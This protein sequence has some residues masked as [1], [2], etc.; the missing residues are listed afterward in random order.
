MSGLFASHLAGH[1]VVWI[2]LV[3]MLCGLIALAVARP[4]PKR[5]S[6]SVGSRRLARSAGCVLGGIVALYLV[7]R[8]IAEFFTVGY[9]NPASYRDSWGG[10]SL[11]GVL[12]V[13]SGPGTAI[14]IATTGYV[15]GW[16]PRSRRMARTDPSP[17]R[18]P[19][20]QTR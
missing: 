3:L 1:V 7:G 2:A 17:T 20:R 6:R 11:L 15:L 5:L 8:G 16:W 14:V 13:H 4:T 9:S 12:L 10:P 19:N 18:E